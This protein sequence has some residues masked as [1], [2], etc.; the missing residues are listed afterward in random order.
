MTIHQYLKTWQYFW[1][2]NEITY[3]PYNLLKNNEIWQLKDLNNLII[4]PQSWVILVGEP[5]SSS[6]H[7]VAALLQH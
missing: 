1:G 4:S 3:Y 6:L 5:I 7:L 2:Q